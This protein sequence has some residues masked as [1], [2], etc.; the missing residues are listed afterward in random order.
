MNQYQ[1]VKLIVQEVV[2]LKKKDRSEEARSLLEEALEEFPENNFLRVSLADLLLRLNRPGEAEVLVEQ[3]LKEDPVD[4]RAWLVKGDLAYQ[5]RNYQQA[6]QFHQQAYQLKKDRF[7]AYRLINT[8]IKLEDYHNA[9]SLCQEWVARETDNKYF[10]KQKA[11]LHQKI[12]NSTA[13]QKILGEYLAEAPDDQFAYKEQIKLKIK[14]LASADAVREL[15][16]LLQVGKRGENIHLHNLLA[17]QLERTGNDQEAVRQYQQA[18]TIEPGNYFTLKKLGFCLVR[19]QREEEALEY[20]K[21]AFQAEPGDYYTRSS[22]FSLFK[23]LNRLEEGIEYFSEIIRE[24]PGFNNLWGI[25]R[26]LA[27]VQKEQEGEG[28]E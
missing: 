3:V 4:Y 12:G 17:E 15:S 8:L 19:L 22:L 16:R 26:K 27:K 2:Q 24:K 7:T 28:D 10:L 21:Q 13:A 23:K 18:L 25:V 14:G 9:L 11:L 1:R 20:L 6:G 5:K